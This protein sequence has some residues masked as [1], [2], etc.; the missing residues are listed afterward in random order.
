MNPLA[1][2]P[3]EQLTHEYWKRSKE[4]AI[5]EG[6]WVIIDNQRLP[7]LAEI[8]KWFTGKSHAAAETEA[9]TTAE[10]QA[11]LKRSGDKKQELVLARA[12]TKALD[13]EIRLRLNKS[14]ADRTEMKSGNLV[15]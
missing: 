12:R 3:N 11:F 9:R 15:T 13:L 1:E 6:E 10:Y 14:F 4:Q 7:V 5:L 2:I 8:T